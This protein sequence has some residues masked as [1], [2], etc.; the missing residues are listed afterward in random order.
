MPSMVVIS[1]NSATRFIFLVQARTTSPFRMTEQAPQTPVPHPT[2]TP[3]RPMRRR[4]SASVSFS[5][6]QVMN[7]ST[8][9]IF[10][11]SRSSFMCKPFCLPTAVSRTLAGQYIAPLPI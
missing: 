6:S 8:P 4:T 5:G 2:L 9:L 11:F 1:E 3:V 7:L 10:K